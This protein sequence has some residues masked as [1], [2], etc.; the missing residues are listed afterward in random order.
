MTTSKRPLSPHLQVY[1]P[2]LTSVLSITH[3][4]TGIFL[5]LGTLLFVYWLVAAA[6]GP[7]AYASAAGVIGSKLGQLVLFA[8]TWALFYHLGNG[9]RHLAWDAGYG[10]DLP[11]VY[12]SGW[13]VVIASAVLTLLCWITV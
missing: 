12:R 5:A 1:R 2:Q 8:W 6:S 11:S 13:T 10:F 9:I 3:R 4:A 7:E